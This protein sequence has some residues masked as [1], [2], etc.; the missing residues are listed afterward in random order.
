MPSY[1]LQLNY[2]KLKEREKK[3]IN[4]ETAV[5]IC[6]HTYYKITVVTKKLLEISKEIPKKYK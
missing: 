5:F 4:Y 2:E 6:P 3:E 1:V